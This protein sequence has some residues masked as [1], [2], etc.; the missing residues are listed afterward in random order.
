MLYRFYKIYSDLDDEMIYVGKTTQTLNK[1]FGE[2]KS[3]YRNNI[4]YCSSKKVFEKY[5]IENVKVVLLEEIE[6]ENKYESDL[7]EREYIESYKNCINKFLPTQTQKERYENNKEI[8]LEK[9]KNYYQTN[10]QKIK[11]CKKEYHSQPYICEVCNITM[12]LSSKSRHNKRQT[13]INN[14]NKNN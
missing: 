3:Y 6:L 4:G 10:I 11:E 7:K 12:N 8:I 2:H 1:R 14:L 13:H 9:N 5:G